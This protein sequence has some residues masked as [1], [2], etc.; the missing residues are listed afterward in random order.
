MISERAKTKARITVGQKLTT[1]ET[2]V[3]AR[4]LMP[5]MP[6]LASMAAL[7]NPKP[8]NKDNAIAV[9]V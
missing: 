3:L 8:A 1:T 4:G 7:P 6:I 2:R 5:C 9:K